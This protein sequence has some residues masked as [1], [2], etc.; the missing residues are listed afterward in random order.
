[1]GV[2]IQATGVVGF[3]DGPRIG[4]QS[5]AGN[6]LQ[7][8]HNIPENNVNVDSWCRVTRFFLGQKSYFVQS[9]VLK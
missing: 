3:D 8:V 9:V 7:R 5:E 4:N 1:M 2:V 6:S